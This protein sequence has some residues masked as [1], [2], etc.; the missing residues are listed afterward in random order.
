MSPG[1]NPP[2]PDWSPSELVARIRRGDRTAEAELVARYSRGVGIILRRMAARHNVVDD[3]YQEVFLRVTEKIRAGEL[4]EPERLSGF[5]SGL[6]RNLAID[7]FR[8]NPSAGSPAEAEADEVPDRDPGPLERLLRGEDEA[9]VRRTMAELSSERD[10]EML[11][12]FYLGDEEKQRICDDLRLTSLQFN[13]VLHRARTR[14]RE[15]YERTV[16]RTPRGRER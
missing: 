11:V 9:C 2:T 14:F 1:L 15:L 8:R 16:A 6:A 13:R 7:Y 5:V 12:R 3:L 4:R 10:R